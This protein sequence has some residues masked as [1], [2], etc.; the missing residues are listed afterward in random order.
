MM[1]MSLRDRKRAW[2]DDDTALYHLGRFYSSGMHGLPKD[3]PFARY[4]FRSAY[5]MGYPDD[6][7]WELGSMCAYGPLGI[8][9]DVMF[10]PESI[11]HGSH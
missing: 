3:E 6:A 11:P 10:W 2:Y 7:M 1:Q 5:V 8:S 4:F 9:R